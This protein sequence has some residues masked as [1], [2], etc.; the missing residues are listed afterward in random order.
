LI[1]TLRPL[2]LERCEP[3]VACRLDLDFDPVDFAFHRG[4]WADMVISLG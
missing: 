4:V 3:F 2:L 1:L